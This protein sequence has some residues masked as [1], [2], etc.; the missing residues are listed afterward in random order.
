MW[1]ACSNR[2]VIELVAKNTCTLSPT[3][4]V[5]DNRKYAVFSLASV[6]VISGIYKG[7]STLWK[8]SWVF[9]WPSSKHPALGA[10]GHRFEP[11]KRSKL[12]Q[13]LISRLTTSWVDDHIKWR[14]PH[15]VPTVTGSFHNQPNIADQLT[16]WGFSPKNKAWKH[17]GFDF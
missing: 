4:F 14:C 2:I 16:V 8:H 13:R 1:I 17:L 6:L 5:N 10:N 7:Q 3:V 15:L 12:F 11:R 9:Q